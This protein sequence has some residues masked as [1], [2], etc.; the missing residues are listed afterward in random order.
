MN[1]VNFYR[2]PSKSYRKELYPNGIYFTTD[3]KEIIVNDISYGTV[4]LKVDNTLTPTST[5]IV[6]SAGIYSGV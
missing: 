1:E 5:N 3:T 6:T 4:D 2:G